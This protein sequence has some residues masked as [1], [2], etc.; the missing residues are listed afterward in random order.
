[1]KKLVVAIALLAVLPCLP[2]AMDDTPE[3]RVAQ[4][5]RYAAASPIKDMMQD[6]AENAAMTLPADQ[7]QEFKDMMTKNL[8]IAVLEKAMKSAMV[9]YFT[10][11]ELKALADFY[12]SAVGKSATKK[13]GAYMAELLPT[14]QAEMTKAMT[15]TINDEKASEPKK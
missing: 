9:K 12:G 14:V 7:R 1:M 13:L 8:D 10:A 2:W 3:N 6:M 11:D 4:A 5:D 15:K